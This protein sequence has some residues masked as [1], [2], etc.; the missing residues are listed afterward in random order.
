MRKDGERR[1]GGERRREKMGRMRGGGGGGGRKRERGRK[2]YKDR[3]SY[4]ILWAVHMLLLLV[5]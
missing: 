3:I 2:V 1:R 4:H 5:S